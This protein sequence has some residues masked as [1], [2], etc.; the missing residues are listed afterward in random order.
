M[1]HTK[2][3]MLHFIYFLHC[4]ESVEIFKMLRI[5]CLHVPFANIRFSVSIL[6]LQC[7]VIVQF[8]QE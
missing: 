1:L 4:V 2:H 7:A 6:G 3:D 5:N 8:Y